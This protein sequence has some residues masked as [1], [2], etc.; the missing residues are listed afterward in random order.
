MGDSLWDT[1]VVERAKAVLG[2]PV[3]IK[4]KVSLSECSTVVERM[5][6]EGLPANIR[7]EEFC[8]GMTVELE[9]GRNQE[10]PSFDGIGTNITDNDPT[11]T[12]KI[13]L[14]HLKENPLYYTL[15]KRYV[16]K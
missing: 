7:M 11:M 2:E 8:A 16:E 4:D 14:A 9:H 6:P 1:G 13:T 5:F 10:D 12:A 15:L 3:P